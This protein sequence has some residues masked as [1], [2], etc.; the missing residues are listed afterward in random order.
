M[1]KV[2]LS[3]EIVGEWLTKGNEILP[4]KIVNGIPPNAFLIDA[5]VNHQT[6]SSSLV[7]TFAESIDD[8]S[9]PSHV[10]VIAEYDNRLK[11]LLEF[12]N[13][14]ESEIRDLNDTTQKTFPEATSDQ[15]TASI[16][17]TYLNRWKYLA[18]YEDAE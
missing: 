1:L 3:D 15:K 12:I 16:L 10:L 11:Q 8:D 18:G 2:E 13:I 14:M 6:D 4:M 9:L 7:L 17:Q 5:E